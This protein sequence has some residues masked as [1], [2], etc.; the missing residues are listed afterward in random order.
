METKSR[1]QTDEIKRL[2]DGQVRPPD[3]ISFAR[4]EAKQ[5]AGMR[6]TMTIHLH[7]PWHHEP[8]RLMVIALDDINTMAPTNINDRDGDW[9][10]S[11]A[12]QSAYAESTPNQR[13]SGTAPNI[14]KRSKAGGGGGGDSSE[15]A[16]T[17]ASS[18]TKIQR[19]ERRDQKRIQREDRKRLAEVARQQRLSKKRRQNN[20]GC[21]VGDKGIQA[22]AQSSVGAT[23]GRVERSVKRS[24]TAKSKEALVHLTTVLDS[25][26]SFHARASYAST[27][28]L[29]R[30]SNRK[31]RDDSD[32][33]S[34]QQ[35]QQI[36]NGVL[37]DP[38]GK[39]TK[40]STLRPESK[41]LQPR[42]RDYNGQGLVRPS[43]YIPFND[44]SFKPKVEME[45]EEHIPGF[46][47]KAKQKAAKKQSDQ[48]M[49]W[50]RCLK[51]KQLAEDGISA[52][53]TKRRKAKKGVGV[54][55]R[56]EGL[57]RRGVM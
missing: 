28:K 29:E 22:P 54:D 30:H 55:D 6:R 14:S 56:V 50:K 7:S 44:P 21:I 41:E 25:T 43:L 52:R 20:D 16:F 18:L 57:M 17:T 26:V 38:K 53:S 11:L 1:R 31:Q 12:R 23:P 48:N 51:A 49:L 9:L 39:A 8:Y 5:E 36:I 35:Q 45:F 2:N 15:G 33:A 24:M 4:E 27:A 40:S 10:A 3:D 37:A 13:G 42:V 19:I 32:S 34:Q 46:F 47:G